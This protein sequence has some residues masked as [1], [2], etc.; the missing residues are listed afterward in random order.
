MIGSLAPHESIF[1]Q[2]EVTLYMHVPPFIHNTAVA[3]FSLQCYSVMRL[4]T[5]G[6]DFPEH[7]SIDAYI[8]ELREEMFLNI[9]GTD[10]MCE[11][12]WTLVWCPFPTHTLPWLWLAES[13]SSA[14]GNPTLQEDSF[15]FSLSSPHAVFNYLKVNA[16]Q[17]RSVNCICWAES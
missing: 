1:R 7:Q 8:H 12:G 10:C 6:A 4:E 2:M 9:S 16:Q 13:L 3:P 17:D 11:G 15:L 14:S 5:G